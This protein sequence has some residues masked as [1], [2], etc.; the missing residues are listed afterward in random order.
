MDEGECVCD[1]CGFDLEDIDLCDGCDAY[2]PGATSCVDCDRGGD[3]TF[4]E[5]MGRAIGAL[6]E[7]AGLRQYELAERAGM[8]P[9]TLARFRAR[10]GNIKTLA[11]IA[12]ALGVHASVLMGEAEE[13]MDTGGEE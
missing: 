13:I 2:V 5:A 1:R 11:K 7:R 6:A 4:D 10:G 12:E 9:N 3:M 8:A